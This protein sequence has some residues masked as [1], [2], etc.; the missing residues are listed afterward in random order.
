MARRFGTVLEWAANFATVGL[1]VV[2]ASF[3]W[4]TRGAGSRPQERIPAVQAGDH[5]EPLPDQPYAQVPLTVVVAVRN[6]CG[7]CTDSMP[8]LRRLTQSGLLTEGR[9]VLVVVAPHSQA[10]LKEYLGSHGV[11]T[12][13]LV[14]LPRESP[15]VRYTPAVFLVD[16]RGT[17]TKAWIGSLDERLYVEIAGSSAES[18]G[19]NRRSDVP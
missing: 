8:Y 17:V 13:R 12:S 10:T 11:V 1:C 9:A 5:A 6:S 2:V 18:V 15:L 16:R 19:Q 4:T 3:V 7:F 14:A